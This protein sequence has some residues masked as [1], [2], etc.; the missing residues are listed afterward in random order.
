MPFSSDPRL[1]LINQ[2]L[3]AELRL[4]LVD[5][6]PASSDASFRRYFR[7]TVGEGSYI[8]MDAPPQHEDVRP[9]IRI[10]NLLR[11]AGI[12]APQIHAL[13]VERGLL[14]LCDFGNRSY[15][16]ELDDTSADRLYGDAT[17]SLLR[18]QR[19]VATDG[20]PPYDDTLLRN[21]MNLFRD[22]FLGRLLS[23]ALNPAELT[24]LEQAWDRLAA[25]AL[26]QPRVCVHRDYHSR[27]LMVTE[28]DNPGVLDFQD[29]VAGPLSYD[30]VSLLKDC[31]I[32]WPYPRID[33]WVADYHRQA[34]ELGLTGGAGLDQF[35]RWFDLMGMQR[36]LK[37]IGIFARLKLRDG[38]SGYLRD[39][40]RTLGYL[41]DTAGRY[42]EFTE[43]CRFLD[44]RD[45]SG[46]HH[47]IGQA[48]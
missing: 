31:Y 21:E 13:D 38:K 2:W 24:L 40:P 27:N 47:A 10:A 5:L 16:A 19:G 25:S 41:R 36:H 3:T 1:Q 11:D 9:F 4:P 8:V 39:I 20:L 42:P 46:L 44:D 6:K 14:L 7:A 22:W 23:P 18:L 45:W 26:E 43:F 48:A 33:A 30:L 12:Q 29:A 32:A 17:A 37:A 15:L 35:R 28:R 34:G